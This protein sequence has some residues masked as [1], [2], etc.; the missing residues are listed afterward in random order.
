MHYRPLVS[1]MLRVMGLLMWRT[2]SWHWKTPMEPTCRE[3]SVMW[4]GSFKHALW[5]QVGKQT[6][7]N[8]LIYLNAGAQI[9]K[10]DHAR[11]LCKWFSMFDPVVGLFYPS[12]SSRIC[13]YLLQ[14]QGPSQSTCLQNPEILAPE[15]HPQQ[16]NP[17]PCAGRLQQHLHHEVF[18]SAGLFG[19]P[20]T[21][22]ERWMVVSGQSG[23]NNY[24][25]V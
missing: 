20:A 19:L 21:E 24:Y 14:V 2:C 6:W 11:W 10:V 12:C 17:I 15:S 13:G 5:H 25:A 23:N 18:S 1:L 8:M 4:S 22:G 9:S 16:R 7:M 3:N